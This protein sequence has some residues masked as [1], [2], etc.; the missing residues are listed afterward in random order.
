[1]IILVLA[2]AAL[3]SCLKKNLNQQQ[4]SAAKKVVT[5]SNNSAIKDSLLSE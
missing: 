1:M 2:L 3:V 5:E 4:Q